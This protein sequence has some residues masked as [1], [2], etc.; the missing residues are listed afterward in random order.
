MKIANYRSPQYENEIINKYPIITDITVHHWPYN[1]KIING[2]KIP[3]D[4]KVDMLIKNT[5]T[6]I[7]DDGY[8]LLKLADGTRS[9]KDIINYV[10]SINNTSKKDIKTKIINFYFRANQEY[11]H[12]R[13][14]DS[15]TE[16]S[17]T[18]RDTGSNYYYFPP[19]F[20]LEITNR[21]NMNCKHCY[22]LSGAYETF[23]LPY[24]DIVYIIDEMSTN[25]AAIIE[26]TG[27]EC[28]LHPDFFN[29]IKYASEKMEIVAVLS[30]GYAL[31]NLM[32]EKIT[33]LKGKEKIVW[34]ISLD[35]YDPAFHDYFRGKSGAHKK[36]CNNIKNL[37]KN[38][39]KVR[40]GMSVTEENFEH[41]KKTMDFCHNELN[42]SLFQYSPVIPVGR[43][44]SS[45]IKITSRTLE[46]WKDIEKYGEKYPGLMFINKERSE[47]PKDENCG[48]GWRSCVFGPDGGIRPCVMMDGNQ[49]KIGNIHEKKIVDYFTED[50]SMSMFF[51]QIQR[52]DIDSCEEG[53][54]DFNFC[55]SCIYR[56]LLTNHERIRQGID[57]CKW[58]KKSNI[59]F[60]KKGNLEASYC[61]TKKCRF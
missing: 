56:A 46:E 38:D 4:K 7:T 53:C 50:G 15:P 12:I 29:T 43:A 18:L 2:G 8:L 30:N 26:L 36:V 17:Y 52:P 57:A 47:M 42:A 40:V 23:D 48:A 35:S 19:H 1:K 60:N 49:Y 51:K 9:I 54:P 28:T 55:W 21:C 6:E 59:N 13:L 44:I 61:Y 11:E 25:G 20:T 5:Q 24:K 31:D 39:F 14:S 45:D 58:A 10:Y 33:G 27:G 37:I 32:I 34:S 16:I 41:I 22:R 3:F